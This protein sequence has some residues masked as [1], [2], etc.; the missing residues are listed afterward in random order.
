MASVVPFLALKEIC[1]VRELLTIKGVKSISE[2]RPIVVNETLEKS[3][4]LEV[5][6]HQCQTTR[7]NCTQGKSE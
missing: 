3:Q 4:C 5:M 7:K 6:S 1:W 2:D